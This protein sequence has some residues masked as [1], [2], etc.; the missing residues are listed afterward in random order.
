MR[1]KLHPVS[2]SI[3]AFI[4]AILLPSKMLDF[5][6]QPIPSVAARSAS[7]WNPLLRS[8]KEHIEPEIERWKHGLDALLVFVSVP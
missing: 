8:V 3:R 2:P 4:L 7:A 6:S 1:D 5:A